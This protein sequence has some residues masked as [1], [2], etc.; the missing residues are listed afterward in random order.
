M[1][2][3]CKGKGIL[4]IQ[5]T[6]QSARP[7]YCPTHYS[8]RHL[9][10]WCFFAHGRIMQHYRTYMP[11]NCAQTQQ[12]SAAT[13]SRAAEGTSMLMLSLIY[14]ID[15]IDALHQ[16]ASAALKQPIVQLGGR[17]NSALPEAQRAPEGMQQTSVQ[18]A[19]LK[20]NCLR[21]AQ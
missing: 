17:A 20:N 14:K 6:Q 12:G 21:R 1:C 7:Q 11:S 5:R 15:C 8:T 19:V 10:G 4:A 2:I 3:G 16:Q 13:A 18:P 9:G